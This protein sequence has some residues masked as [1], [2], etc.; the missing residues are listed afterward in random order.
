MLRVRHGWGV[1]VDIYGE[2]AKRMVQQYQTVLLD[3]AE[4]VADAK[5]KGYDCRLGDHIRVPIA[6][7]LQVIGV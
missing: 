2:I 7:T 1:E 6:P 4:K 5:S 3:T